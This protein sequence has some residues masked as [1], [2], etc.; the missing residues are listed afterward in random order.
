MRTLIARAQAKVFSRK[1]SL[2]RLIRVWNQPK[3]YS[4]DVSIYQQKLRTVY[5]LF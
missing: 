5:N 2:M 3:V 1:T 4:I